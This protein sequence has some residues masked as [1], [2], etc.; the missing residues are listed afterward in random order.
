MSDLFEAIEAGDNKRVSVL[1]RKGYSLNMTNDRRQT[2][3]H[4]AC[5]YDNSKC[6][7]KLLRS[8][9]DT[10]ALDKE[11][12]TPL[13]IACAYQRYSN[14]KALL[15]VGVDLNSPNNY[16]W[17]P[18]HIA[19]SMDWNLKCVHALIKAGASLNIQNKCERTPLHVACW[20]H[21]DQYIEELLKA[22]CNPNIQDDEGKTPLHL[23]IFNNSFNT[24]NLLIEYQA[25]LDIVD[26][27][28]R[29]PLCASCCYYGKI[30]CTK[31]LLKGSNINTQNYCGWTPLHWACYNGEDL[32][33]IELLQ[34]GGI[35]TSI[36]NDKGLTALQL[37]K[38][39]GNHG[40]AKL[41]ADYDDFLVIKEPE[42]I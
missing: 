12:R 13:Y 19:C 33:V 24:V 21:Q 28:G 11:G 27:K 6:V 3:L 17:T 41:I 16:G 38:R 1:L 10:E 5:M 42:F 7:R 37:A 31:L 39:Y 14:V 32:S 36:T 25:Q 22:G 15:K 18:L 30:D 40:V 9:C 34:A 2:P 23:A 35:D 26:Q 4:V 20:N 8:G 29:T